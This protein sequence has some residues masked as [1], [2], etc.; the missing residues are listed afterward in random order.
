M[1]YLFSNNKSIVFSL[2]LVALVLSS[3]QQT[4]DIGKS[5]DKLNP[6][7]KTFAKNTNNV[8]RSLYIDERG[9]PSEQIFL[10]SWGLQATE[11]SNKIDPYFKI[12]FSS[13]DIVV[14][15]GKLVSNNKAKVLNLDF[16]IANTSRFKSLNIAKPVWEGR[17]YEDNSQLIV[18]GYSSDFNERPI[19]KI[20]CNGLFVTDLEDDVA[21]EFPLLKIPS[22]Q[23]VYNPFNGQLIRLIP[24]DNKMLED[25]KNSFLPINLCDENG[26]ALKNIHFIL[27]K[28]PD[29]FSATLWGSIGDTKFKIASC[30]FSNAKITNSTEG[31]RP[32]LGKG[33]TQAGNSAITTLTFKGEFSEN[34]VQNKSMLCISNNIL[35]GFA[36]ITNKKPV[37]NNSIVIDGD[38]SDWHNI[39]STSDEKGDFVS[40]LYPNPDTDILEFKVTNDEKNLYIYTRVAGAHGRTGKDGRYYWYTYI[41]VDTNPA[42]GYVPTRD[43]NCYYGV[44]IGDDCEAQFEFIDNKFIKT[45]FGFTG[46]G[47]E[48]DVLVGKLKLGPSFYSPE[49]KAGNKRDRYKIEYV[50]KGDKRAIT[51]DYTKGTSDDIVI[52]LSAD[53]SEMELKVELAGFLQDVSGRK[54]M[55][56]G[57]QIDIAVGA[58]AS[59]N[60]YGSKWWGADSSPTVYGYTLK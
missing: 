21:M 60:F 32:E 16:F 12:S 34:I 14:K 3:C 24:N 53:A 39:K 31:F 51:H 55:Q 37:R 48:K 47:A 23:L 56:L 42:T 11:L 10:R 49:D 41:D 19:G 6:E 44:A 59:S 18:G 4:K 20:N 35:V 1:N 28:S 45:F 22:G 30:T 9:I 38:L 57:Q 33:C 50:K 52:A 36:P 29:N 17:V 8:I 58:E 40:Y 15:N 5:I 27:E 54:L 43:D 26:K 7:T 2:T 25:K 13:K 46:N